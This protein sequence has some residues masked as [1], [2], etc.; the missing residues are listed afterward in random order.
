MLLKNAH[1]DFMESINEFGDNYNYCI[2]L[3][4][5]KM[6]QVFFLEK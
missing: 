3:S 1:V 4:F 5:N 2:C 6:M